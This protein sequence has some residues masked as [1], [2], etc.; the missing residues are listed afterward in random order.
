M[1]K[2]IS[3]L[4]STR[5]FAAILVVIYHFGTSVFPFSYLPGF[6]NSGYV[7]VS[8]FFVLS[9]FILYYVNY[10][11]DVD[12]K[13][14]LS[15]R[16]ARILPMYYVALLLQI[17]LVI[18]ES[19]SLKGQW[20]A[21]ISN[22]LLVQASIPKYAF[23]LNLPAWSLS[24]EAFFY[25]LFPLLF[26][27][28]R[29]RPGLFLLSALLAYIGSQLVM[30]YKYPYDEKLHHT[31]HLFL[32]YH[33]VMHINQFLIGMLTGHFYYRYKDKLRGRKWLLFIVAA[34]L[35]ICMS[36]RP[37]WISYQ[38][39][40]LALLFALLI[41]LLST[42]EPKILANRTLVVLGE[43]SYSI[44][45]LHHPLY[46]WMSKLN[47]GYL[48]EEPFFYLYIVVLMML[49]V[50][51]YFIIEIPMRRRITRWLVVKAK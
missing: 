15:K 19:G 47:H 11:K 24:V 30:G 16:A 1:E 35:F 21:A 9:G 49:S 31:M 7:C 8:Y 34:T 25:I 50:L 29:K 51:G 27:W 22:V 42:N 40:L 32:F 45:I 3:T 20:G 46:Q 18:Y 33:P 10:G 26:V 5:F 36:W 39:G 17:F 6:F 43:A 28:Q 23:T 4:T 37:G 14:F 41:M 12:H 48:G 13:D 2:H 44:Y 38:V